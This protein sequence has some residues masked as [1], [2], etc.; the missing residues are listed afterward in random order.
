M[1]WEYI[2]PNYVVEGDGFYIS[3]NPGDF[4][5]DCFSADTGGDET[6]LIKNGIFYILNGDWR[7]DYESLVTE[8]FEICLNFFKSKETEHGSSWSTKVDA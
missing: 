7:T 4:V 1:E 3:Y 5:L 6:A 2:G 8:G